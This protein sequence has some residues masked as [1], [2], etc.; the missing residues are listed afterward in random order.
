MKKSQL[1]LSLILLGSL[2]LSACGTSNSTSEAMMDETATLDA[3]M[4]E[5]ATPEAMMHDTPT[6]DA[7]MHDT[8]TA[9]SMMEASTPDAMMELPAWF[10][11]ALTD[12]K[13]GNA[14]TINDFK[15]KVVLVEMMA[16]WCST[17]KQQQDQI[18]AQKAIV[19]NLQ[20]QLADVQQKIQSIDGTIALG[21]CAV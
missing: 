5:S 17:C 7:M 21:G 18:K 9:D 13:S 3:M 16:V 15:G 1:L 11:A 4:K 10:S 6:P 8:P 19:I 2:L 14:F 20:S 12:A